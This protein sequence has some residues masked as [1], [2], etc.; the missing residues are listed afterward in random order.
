MTRPPFDTYRHACA[1]TLILAGVMLSFALLAVVAGRGDPAAAA[2]RGAALAT[3][4]AALVLGG[5]GFAALS[6][7]NATESAHAG[8]AGERAKI[9]QELTARTGDR[10]RLQRELAAARKE[11]AERTGELTVLRAGFGAVKNDGAEVTRL[12]AEV[13]RLSRLSGRAD[14]ARKATLVRLL[15]ER[16]VARED[17]LLSDADDAV[18]E[19]RLAAVDDEFGPRIEAAYDAL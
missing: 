18:R 11:L 13:D 9:Q 7:V 10:D 8:H 19:A 4:F 16:A 12:R 6:A 2:E 14:P 17:A 15:E 5:V 3:V 1:G